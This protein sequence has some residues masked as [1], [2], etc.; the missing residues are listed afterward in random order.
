MAEKEGFIEVPGGRVWYCIAGAEK[1]GVPLLIL[2]GGPGV[3]HDY[4]QT[5]KSLA[6]ERP[7]IFYDQ[8]GCGNSDR[9]SDTALWKTERFVEELVRVRA[10]LNLDKVHILGQSWGTMLAIEYMLREKPEGIVS[11]VLSAPYLSTLQWIEDQKKWIKQFPVEVQDTITK[12]ETIGDYS[13]PSYQDAMMFFYRRHVCRLDPWPDCM[14]DAM[15]KIG[16]DVYA[17]MWG[18][19]EF[20]MNGTLK[21]VDLTKQLNEI[22]VPVLFT[23]GE[24]DEATPSTTALYQS[25]LPGSEIYIFKGASHE[26]HLE[27]TDEYNQVI[28]SFL[29]RSEKR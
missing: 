20:T 8:L 16:A 26:H 2:H 15:E 11:L 10:A 22:K 21:T 19:S 14:N 27:K 5:I 23:C 1:K 12:Y 18:A 25:K 4:L 7:V 13:S 29:H 3:P 9:P 24:F 28:R 6:D 17:K